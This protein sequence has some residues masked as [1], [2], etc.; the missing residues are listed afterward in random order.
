ME[1]WEMLTQ[2]Q[3]MTADSLLAHIHGEPDPLRVHDVAALRN[4][5][6]DSYF[7]KEPT[8]MLS[9][10][11]SKANALAS[12]VIPCPSCGQPVTGLADASQQYKA[13]PSM[14]STLDCPFPDLL[15]RMSYTLEPC[16]CRVNP[17]WAAEFTKEL[18]RRVNGET[19]LTVGDMTS[20]QR[21]QQVKKI[22]GQIGEL[23]SRL[24]KATSEEAKSRIQYYLV[25]AVDHLM[26]LLPGAHNCIKP[27]FLDPEVRLWAEK[28]GY[29]SPVPLD[30]PPKNNT[31]DWG[32]AK[33]YKM[34][35]LGKSAEN[36]LKSVL[37]KGKPTLLGPDQQQVEQAK[38]NIHDVL[39]LIR[40]HRAFAESICQQHILGDKENAYDALSCVRDDLLNYVTNDIPLAQPQ[41]MMFLN[42][43]E[44]FVASSKVMPVSGIQIGTA[45]TLEAVK[46][47]LALP[48]SVNPQ[49][50]PARVTVIDDILDGPERKILDVDLD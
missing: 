48:S 16:S 25:I 4:L 18:N 37:P 38:K 39:N 43:L 8:V 21:H 17:E 28:N 15:Q 32:Y 30:G 50:T 23:Y 9:Q 3:G 41:T 6:F 40:D 33:D 10:S 12:L 20:S 42:A 46:P 19:P 26:C 47:S 45:V 13:P 49:G 22:E 36:G 5:L 34:P 7:A 2:P 44:A 11:E 31:A 35:K 27:V 1:P 29:K 14:T 24:N